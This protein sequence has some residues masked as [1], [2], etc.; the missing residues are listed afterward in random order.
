MDLNQLVENSRDVSVGDLIYGSD[1]YYGQ[2]TRVGGSVVEFT[3]VGLM[4]AGPKGDQ[5]NIGI[6]GPPGPQGIQGIPG[7]VQ[8]IDLPGYKNL[9]MPDLTNAIDL[10]NRQYRIYDYNGITVDYGIDSGN[11][12]MNGSS[13]GP[14]YVW[15]TLLNKDT[16]VENISFSTYYESGCAD[17]G[18]YQWVV[19]G[20]NKNFW[21]YVITF[22]PENRLWTQEINSNVQRIGL[23]FREVEALENYTFKLQ[24]EKGS[25]ITPYTIPG[26]IPQY[27]TQEQEAWITPTLLNGATGTIKYRKNQ[28][29]RVEFKGSLNV[30]NSEKAQ[31]VLPSGYFPG[32]N[33]ILLVRNLASQDR[34]LRINTAG[35]FDIFAGNGSF[36]FN[37]FS[38]I[39]EA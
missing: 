8:L 18:K 7:E 4:P 26:K 30:T 24:V 33:L 15:I 23:F 22:T 13:S 32:Y 31:F 6:Q 19:E 39:G 5:G 3:T 38:F 37:W 27:A 25:T 17:S 29:G 20:D 16:Y 34:T 11:F 35:G 1:A 21:S 28:W 2:V 9:A 36:N 10:G 14:G 12:V